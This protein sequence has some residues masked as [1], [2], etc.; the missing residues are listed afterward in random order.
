MLAR[1]ER[2]IGGLVARC[3]LRGFGHRVVVGTP[4]ELDGVAN[5]RID[6]KRYV[7]EDT[8]GRCDNNSVRG[9]SAIVSGV[10]GSRSIL[11]SRCRTV[12]CDAL[13]IEQISRVSS[14]IRVHESRTSN[15]V[16]E[17]RVTPV[18]ATGAVRW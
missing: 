4:H 5:S 2:S 9:A 1:D 18:S 6:C 12:R 13:C 3:E 7:S 17:L 8:L 16:L 15:T 10:G 14:M 11:R